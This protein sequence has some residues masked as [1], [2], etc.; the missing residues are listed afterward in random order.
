MIKAALRAI[1]LGT[2][3]AAA[4]PVAFIVSAFGQAHP[5]LGVIL[6]TIAIAML[7]IAV[8]FVGVATGFV[9]VGLPLTAMLSRARLETARIYTGLGA[10][11]GFALPTAFASSSHDR[12]AA[13]ISLGPWGLIGGGVT[14]YI[15]FKHGR[16][17]IIEATERR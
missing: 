14:A 1:L 13:A 8:A 6:N 7:P 5:T 15:W 10:T 4:L 9:V 11:L 16:R 17:P 2:L 12:L 3:A